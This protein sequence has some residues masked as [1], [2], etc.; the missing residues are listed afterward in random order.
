M[1]DA[2]V[3][4]ITGASS[5]MGEAT[6]RAAVAAGYRVV[7]GARREEQLQALAAQ[8]GGPEHA[9]ARRCDVKLWEDVEGLANAGLETFGR[10]D[11][12]LANAG[13]GI[14]PG[15]LNE[16]PEHWQH[17]FAVNTLGV[18]FTIRAT[19]A[20]VLERGT[21]TYLLMG[22]LSGRRVTPG[23]L[24]SATKYGVSAMA[25]ALRQELR[26]THGNL[27][28]RVTIL[29]PGFVD[30]TYYDVKPG[31]A[32]K[33]LRG[34]TAEDMA[35][36]VMLVLDSDPNVEFNEIVMRPAGQPS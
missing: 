29:Q 10:I 5:G 4:L 6:A 1:S 19:L 9:L 8:L 22:S 26:M 21:G 32:A 7:L 24:Y 30:T 25:D 34:L 28:I 16:S 3:L 17:A 33:G 18:A 14:Y 2:P 20:H 27:A 11:A 13:I 23:S 15:F 36:T 12:V 35:R 31:L